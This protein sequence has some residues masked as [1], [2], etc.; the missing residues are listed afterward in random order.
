MHP[1]RLYTYAQCTLLVNSLETNAEHTQS[2]RL[3]VKSTIAPKK[4]D[5]S[6]DS[7]TIYQAFVA[8]FVPSTFGMLFFM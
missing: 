7:A 5:V 6:C 4:N 1:E 2:Q 3:H 8:T